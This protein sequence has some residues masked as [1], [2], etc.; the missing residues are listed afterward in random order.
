MVGQQGDAPVV[1][2]FETHGFTVL[3]TGAAGRLAAI[4]AEGQR[5]GAVRDDVT[6]STTADL[7]VLVA[8]GVMV[9]L[10]VGLP[11]DPAALRDT[12]LRVLARGISTET[13]S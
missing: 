11:L 3:L 8:L 2:W 4:A 10:D 5:A 6:A 13:G 7:L 9:A 12:V 1:S